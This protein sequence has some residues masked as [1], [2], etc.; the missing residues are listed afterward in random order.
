MV[1]QQPAS[2]KPPGGSSSDGAGLLSVFVQTVALGVFILACFLIYRNTAANLARQGIVSGFEFM[3]RRSGFNITPHL[4]AF[5]PEAS[6]ARALLVGFLNT[7]LLSAIAIVASTILGFLIRLARVSPNWLARKLSLCYVETFRNIPLLLQIFFWY[8]GVLRTLPMPRESIE[9][10]RAIFLNN[11]GFYVPIPIGDRWLQLVGC[12]LLVSLVI[13]GGRHFYM[14]DG[15]HRWWLDV[16]LLVGLP[17][18]V[19]LASGFGVTW[20]VPHISGFNFVGG[21]ALSPELVA[22]AIALSTYQTSFIAE[23]VRGGVLSVPRG[24]IEAARS[25]GLAER[26]ILRLIVLPQA[27]RAILPPLITLH[28]STLK[29]SSLGAAIGY[30]ELV[31]VFAGTTLSLVGQAVEIMS[32]T[33]MIYLLMGLIVS[34]VLNI[35]DWRLRAR[36]GHVSG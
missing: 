1:A 15:Q 36:E 20:D 6:F 17:L 9:L 29:N 23:A 8:F 14:R 2:P 35:V 26:S 3:W 7:L 21:A 18:A 32:V 24:Q 28:L 16:A 25:L 12:G 13:I 34:G 11:R 19:A 4:V 22:I 5:G 27:L 30:P 31:S 10:F 33:L